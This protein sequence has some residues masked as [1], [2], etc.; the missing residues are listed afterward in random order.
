MEER[1]EADDVPSA[2]KLSDVVADSQALPT[3]DRDGDTLLG[4]D[5]P[6]VDAPGNEVDA[7]VLAE[8]SIDD[9]GKSRQNAKCRKRKSHG[10]VDESDNGPVEEETTSVWKS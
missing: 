9:D 7:L 4:A 10:D 5:L 1:A 8:A 6:E 3:V 2:T